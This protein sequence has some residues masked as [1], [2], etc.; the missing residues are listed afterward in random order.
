MEVRFEE[1]GVYA[2]MFNG[3]KVKASSGGKDGLQGPAPG[4]FDLLVASIALCSAGF[5]KAFF[6]KNNI[7]MN[8]VY[9]EYMPTIE[10]G[11]VLTK[12]VIKIHIPQDNALGEGMFDALAD[13][14]KRCYVAKNT[15][16]FHI[17]EVV[18]DV[19]V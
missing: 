18:R 7:D 4:P 15:K 16:A 10:T 1:N 6:E 12:V 3:F 19:V 11:H 8:G 13:F 17:I 14:V 2:A 5:V 9:L